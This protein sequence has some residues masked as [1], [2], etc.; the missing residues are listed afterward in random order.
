M[1]AMAGWPERGSARF[2]V[3]SNKASA[4]FQPAFVLDNETA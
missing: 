3:Q 4:T 2:N 1:P